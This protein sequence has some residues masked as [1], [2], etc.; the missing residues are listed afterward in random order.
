MPVRV[1]AELWLPPRI[2]CEC[3]PPLL[4]VR[5]LPLRMMG[6]D[7]SLHLRIDVVEG[8]VTHFHPE[9]VFTPIA[10]ENGG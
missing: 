7:H 8:L 4:P 6:A 5:I 3:Y 9:L 1:G 10:N 2:V